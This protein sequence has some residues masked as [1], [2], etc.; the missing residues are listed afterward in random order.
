MAVYPEGNPGVSPVNFATDLGKFRLFINDLIGVP[1]VPPELGFA[2]YSMASDAEIEAFI[3]S[4]TSTTRAVSAFFASLA[5]AAST[6]AVDIKDHDLQL[7]NTLLYKALQEQSLFWWNR[8][9]DEELL[10]GGGD[11]F[12]SFGF[13]TDWAGTPEAAPPVV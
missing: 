5:G 11:I 13:G 3:A 12:D 2:N 9:N 8:A 6:R 10:M 4:A 7:K 1:Y